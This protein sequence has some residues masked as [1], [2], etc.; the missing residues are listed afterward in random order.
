MAR[1]VHNSATHNRSQI[2]PS[3]KRRLILFFILLIVVAV[4]GILTIS[5]NLGRPIKNGGMD[6]FQLV[7]E[8]FKE[9]PT[10]PR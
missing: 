6:L 5:Y 9:E 2:P 4:A 8:R 7:A 10:L 3:D 1:P